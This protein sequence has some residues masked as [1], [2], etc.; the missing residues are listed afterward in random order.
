MFDQVVVLSVKWIHIHSYIPRWCLMGKNIYLLFLTK[1]GKNFLK[2]FQALSC[3]F[4]LIYFLLFIC[5]LA[6]VLHTHC[7]SGLLPIFK[8]YQTSII[9]RVTRESHQWSITVSERGFCL[10]LQSLVV[11]C[12]LWNES[13]T[14]KGNWRKRQRLVN[15]GVTHVL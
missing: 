8:F 11:V 7:M 10:N 4:F 15:R 9:Q 3:F 12:S 6:F 1:P 2:N 14:L 13:Q 5:V